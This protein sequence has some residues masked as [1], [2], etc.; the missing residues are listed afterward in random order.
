MSRTVKLEAVTRGRV[1]VAG[2]VASAGAF[3]ALL[4]L[5]AQFAG[6]NPDHSAGD[7]FMFAK[8][9]APGTTDPKAFEPSCD[10]SN[11]KQADFSGSSSFVY[12]RIHSNA[13]VANSGAGNTFVDSG[14]PN[15]EITYGV[16]DNAPPASPPDC[17]LQA[18][19]A[20]YNSGAP[21]NIIASGNPAQVDGPYQIGLHGWPG[22]LGS[23]LNADGETF[24]NDVTQVLPGATCGSGTSLTDTDPY[25]VQLSD[26]GKVICNGTGLI[27]FAQ[28]GMGSAA[29]PFEITL[30][31][32]G[33]ISMD[34]SDLV[35]APAAHGVLAWTDLPFSVNPTAIKLAG[36]G[37]NVLRRSILFTPRSGQD[38]SGSDQ[39]T[40]C[41][42]MIGQGALKAAGS[43]DHFGPFGPGCGA[44]PSVLTEIHANRGGNAH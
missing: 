33:L 20:A 29:D 6:A 19:P 27:T 31:S 10:A 22:N 37:I 43:Q 23:F 40:L 38:V 24:G 25:E 18:E 26:E 17:Q 12:G 32:H 16:N 44:S 2:L 5:S 41:L 8:V 28:Q 36:Q 39:V 1:R 7:Y 35:L 13:D 30:I 11:H 21:T 9:A 34:K 15:T 14:S 3:A 42:Q 4:L